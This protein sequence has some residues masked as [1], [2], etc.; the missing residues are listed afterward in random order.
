VKKTHILIGGT[1]FLAEGLN[2]FGHKAA[3]E[4]DLHI[5]N[6][7]WEKVRD[8]KKIKIQGDAVCIFGVKHWVRKLK[9]QR[10]D[11][12]KIVGKIQDYLSHSLPKNIPLCLVEDLELRSGQSVGS[13]L[14]S[15][16]LKYFNCRCVLLREYL[17]NTSYHKRVH[18]FAIYSVD[19]AKY[20]RSIDKKNV[21]VF[22][23]G[24]DSS[25]DRVKIVKDISGI[26]NRNLEL[27]VYKGGEKSKG[28]I[29][30]DDF[31]NRLGNSKIA[32][33]MMGNGYSCFRYQ[34]VASVGSL[35]AAKKYPLVVPY[36][37][38]DMRSCIKFDKADDL[39]EK[40]DEALSSRDRISD[41]TN[42]CR[43]HF[44]KYHTTEKRFEEFLSYLNK[45]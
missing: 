15:M 12:K 2:F 10:L 6:I 11:A 29:S 45:L 31:Y 23:R 44:L 26:K 13:R 9:K 33:S 38:E 3:K 37:Y 16:L 5:D 35:L 30:R 18:P 1:F 19:R 28:K 36:D 27:K 7:N 40:I 41:M 8:R 24:D 17:R 39:R 32:L 34:E 20:I 43:E 14:I 25:K 22:F 4:A 42:A 21:D